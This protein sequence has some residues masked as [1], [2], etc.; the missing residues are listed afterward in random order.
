MP[1]AAILYVDQFQ[2]PNLLF[3]NHGFHVFAIAVATLEGLFVSYVSW[4]CYRESGEP[5][6]RWLTAGFLGFTLIYAPHGFFTPLAHRNVW[7]FILYGPASRFVMA[8]SLLAAIWVFGLKPHDDRTRKGHGFW[9]GW[10]A[11][12][13]A[14]DVGVAILAFSPIA[15]APWVRLSM[16]WG[17]LIMS[18]GCAVSMLIRRIAAPLMRLYFVAAC[19]FAQSSYA[20]TLGKVWNHQWWLAHIIFASGFFLLSYGV[21]RAFLTTGAFST[22]HSEERMMAEL[23]AAKEKAE[24]ASSAKSSFLANMSHEIRTPMNAILGMSQ[25]FRQ[26]ELDSRQA[27]YVEKIDS[28]ARTLLG[29]LNDILDF[30]KVEAGK[31][32]LDLQPFDLDKLLRDVGV[33]L[34]ANVGGKDVEILFDIDQTVPRWIVGDAL[35][36]QQILINLGGNAVKF[37]ERGEVVLSA[38]LDRDAAGQPVVAVSVRDTGIGVPADKITTIFEGFSQAEHSIARRFGGTGLGLAI[39]QRLVALMGGAITVESQFGVGSTFRFTFR[40]EPSQARSVTGPAAD[41]LK[42]LTALVVDDNDSARHVLSAMVQSFGWMSVEAATGGE[43]L[44][45]LEVKAKRK[46]F[47]DIVLLDWRMPHMDGWETAQRIK[48]LFDGQISPLI[49]MVTAYDREALEERRTEAPSLLDHFLVKP[50]TASMLFDA[51]A[52]AKVGAVAKAPPR[53][54]GRQTGKLDGVR[55]L[56]VEDNPTNQQV[57]RELL[58]SAG[59]D[60]TVAEGGVPALEILRQ[61][62]GLFDLV[63]MD[64]QMPDL[65]GYAATRQIRGT[66]GLRELPVVAMTA[67]AMSADRQAALE[68]GMNDHVAKPFDLADLVAVIGRHV[69]TVGRSSKGNG[70]APSR[71]PLEGGALDIGGAL[72]RFCDDTGIYRRALLSFAIEA[73]RLVERILVQAGKGA[74]A[75]PREVGLL[76]HSL[77]GAAAQIGADPLAA[78]LARAETAPVAALQPWLPDIGSLADQAVATARAVAARWPEEEDEDAG[79]RPVLEDELKRLCD[80]LSASNMA[81]LDGYEA[82]RRHYAGGMPREFEELG[83]AIH[84]LDFA[85]ALRIC[86]SMQGEL[87]A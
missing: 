49:V 61:H 77:K 76:L 84:K 13:V 48:T 72:A 7:L 39:S 55:L 85:G 14:I 11:A 51:V 46:E 73:P 54:A 31:L 71:G 57:A 59:A 29:I 56:L 20:F 83:T 6:L 86:E 87:K 27:D 4:S 1:L 5:F 78:M 66:L 22:V 10:I 62:A 15:G 67:N 35:R 53:R 34:S 65:D 52:E 18:V 70:S 64:V 79:D 16:E 24:A 41:K 26:T 80:L 37:T 17:A 19:F 3:M 12:Y 63:L 82:L 68:A 50:I 23:A 2:D 21:V 28:A 9:V 32:E 36:L 38:R 81:A 8:G 25:L 43:A 69:N 47:F 33:I 60:V 58:Q 75:D 45:I 44:S 30:S 74:G 42:A 40:F